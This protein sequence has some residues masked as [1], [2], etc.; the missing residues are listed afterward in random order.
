VNDAV[1]AVRGGGAAW[2]RQFVAALRAE[3][4]PSGAFCCTIVYADHKEQ[5][6]NGF[7]TALVLRG[8]RRLGHS[9]G[10]DGTRRRALDFLER[11]ADPEIPGAYGFWPIAERPPWAQGIP[12]DSDDTAVLALE[13]YRHERR[14]LRQTRDTVYEVL[15]PRLLT[16]FDRSGPPWI[17]PLTFPTWLSRDGA[18]RANPV[19]CCV[20]ANVL[21]LM[22]VCGLQH[23]PGYDESC[24]MIAAALAWAAAPE[25]G[26]EDVARQRTLR[27]RTLTPYYPDPAAF[28]TAV[29]HAVAC[30]VDA[31][32]PALER[33]RDLCVQARPPAAARGALCSNAYGGYIWRCRALDLVA[34]VQ[35]AREPTCAIVNVPGHCDCW[36]PAHEKERR[37]HKGRD[38]T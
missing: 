28:L 10:L 1:L 29:T 2:R 17:R 3:Q 33:L 31:L 14:T 6:G 38:S 8:L 24:A 30:G 16:H 25:K 26:L 7:A 5:D 18:R 21:A 19:D 27:L 22:A 13:L 32:Q 23:L 12:A 34:A 4:A 9:P 36:P 15:V 35:T 20:N 37:Q 11:C